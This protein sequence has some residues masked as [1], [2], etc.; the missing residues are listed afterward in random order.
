MF[1]VANTRP[2]CCLEHTVPPSLIEWIGRASDH[3]HLDLGM[4]VTKALRRIH[5]Q[6]TSLSFRDD[7]DRPDDER[8]RPLTYLK[9]SFW[10]W[11]RPVDDL[12][13]PSARCIRIRARLGY[14]DAPINATPRH[15]THRLG[16]PT[17]RSHV[18]QVHDGGYSHAL[19]RQCLGERV[20][21]IGVNDVRSNP[22][23][24]P[25]E[26]TQIAGRGSSATSN[27]W[28][29]AQGLE[30]RGDRS[31]SSGDVMPALFKPVV[32]RTRRR[33]P[34]RQSPPESV[35]RLDQPQ[36]SD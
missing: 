31:R 8:A 11:R 17:G 20:Q 21:G 3:P 18:V 27:T 5:E 13:S 35:E 4:A 19:C 32:S 14:S 24:T 22:S 33:H 6:V 15:L 36:N 7:A 25:G 23:Y 10:H 16:L 30:P 1:E 28:R 2:A 9:G 26:R 12:G 34:E 29:L